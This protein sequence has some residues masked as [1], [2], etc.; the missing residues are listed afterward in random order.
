MRERETGKGDPYSKHRTSAYCLITLQGLTHNANDDGARNV[1]RPPLCRSLWGPALVSLFPFYNSFAFSLLFYTIVSSCFTSFIGVLCSLHFNGFIFMEYQ[2]NCIY[3]ILGTI[4]IK[5]ST[6]M[7][8]ISS[9]PSFSREVFFSK[10][11]D[12]E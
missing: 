5:T 1:I 7:A 12:S 11:V 9:N 8:L 3:H 4:E 6:Q 2:I 10:S